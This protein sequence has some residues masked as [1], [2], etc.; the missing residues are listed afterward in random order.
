MSATRAQQVVVLTRYSE[1][2]PDKIDAIKDWLKRKY[3]HDPAIEIETVQV[4]EEDT[5]QILE[6]IK[7][8]CQKVAIVVVDFMR[9]EL[10]PFLKGVD[11]NRCPGF[12]W[13]EYMDNLGKELLWIVRF[14]PKP[15]IVWKRPALAYA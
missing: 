3:G 7:D 9:S 4:S 11:P 12:H 15:E 10:K 14:A 8:Y 2:R 5:P 6:I 13:F 1:L